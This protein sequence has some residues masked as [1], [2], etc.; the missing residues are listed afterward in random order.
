MPEA[1]EYFI[2]L[3]LKDQ[4]FQ[5]PVARIEM[6]QAYVQDLPRRN[7]SLPFDDEEAALGGCGFCRAA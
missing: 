1:N 7:V 2:P 3:P 5:S 6:Y 4:V